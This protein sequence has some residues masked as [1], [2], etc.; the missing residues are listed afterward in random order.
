MGNRKIAEATEKILEALGIDWEEDQ[1]FQN[2][3]N[4]VARAFMERNQRLLDDDERRLDNILSTEFTS[5]YSDFVIVDPIRT[6]SL[7]SH[8]LETVVLNAYIGYI[9]DEEV[10]GLSKIP[11]AVEYLTSRP[12]LQEDITG[13][14]ADVL[15]ERLNPQSL[16]VHVEGEHHCLVSRGAEEKDASMTTTAL[17]GDAR[18][19]KT[20]VDE[21]FSRIDNR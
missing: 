9:P 21:F 18:E 20:Q 13:E 1:N 8:H 14:I 3:P 12:T 15:D 19:N 17:R 11:R 16:I 5:G 2:T 7:C 10:V 4:R 6:A